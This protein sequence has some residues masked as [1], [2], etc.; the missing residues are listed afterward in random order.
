MSSSSPLQIESPP[1]MLRGQF[2]MKGDLSN[3]L[4][5]KCTFMW[6]PTSL[7]RL[8]LIKNYPGIARNICF[9]GLFIIACQSMKEQKRQRKVFLCTHWWL[10]VVLHYESTSRY[11]EQISKRWNDQFTYHIQ[12]NKL[13]WWVLLESPFSKHQKC[14][15]N[16]QTLFF[17]FT[18]PVFI[19]SPNAV[20]LP[21]I[22]STY[23]K[24]DDSF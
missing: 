6:G 7:C 8:T 10:A 4:K 18:N 17:S 23:L 14:Q 12:D 3:A 20:F 11:V 2:H 5:L 1:P 15:T 13:L 22:N 21:S 16:P 24:L 9:L 19:I